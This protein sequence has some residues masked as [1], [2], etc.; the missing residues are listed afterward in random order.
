MASP[1]SG[2]QTSQKHVQRFQPVISVVLRYSLWFETVCQR[3]G[4][5]LYFHDQEFLFRNEWLVAEEDIT[6]FW[7][8]ALKLT[9][10]CYI[11]RWYSSAISQSITCPFMT[12]NESSS[13]TNRF[14]AMANPWVHCPSHLALDCARYRPGPAVR[15]SGNPALTHLQ[16]T[17]ICMA[18]SSE[19]MFWRNRHY[20]GNWKLC[21]YMKH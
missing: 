15:S 21:K 8:C 20:E 6:V 18:R 16:G 5:V 4:N 11:R 17:A 7:Y 12:D 10:S 9:A 1:T 3:F 14:R 19:R 2:F 13:I